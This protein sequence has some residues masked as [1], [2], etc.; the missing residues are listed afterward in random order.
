MEP[1]TDLQNAPSEGSINPLAGNIALCLSGGGYRAAA[2]HLG[3]LKALDEINVIDQVKYLSTASGGTILAAKFVTARLSG[4]FDFAAFFEE[5]KSFLT[6]VN[7]VSDSFARLNSNPDKTNKHS[8]IRCA[9]AVYREKLIGENDKWT[10]GSLKVAIAETKIFEDLIFNSSEFRT[11][12]NFRF[13]IANGRRL[14]F[15]NRNTQVKEELADQIHLADIVAASSCFPG[16]FEPIIFPQEFRLKDRSEAGNPFVTK[17]TKFNTL[18]LMDGG[19]LD[20]QGLYGMT[21]SYQDASKIPF[22]LLFVSD[23][24]GKEDHIY[25]TQDPKW[26]IPVSLRSVV[27]ILALLLA[28]ILAS[29]LTTLWWGTVTQVSIWYRLAILSTG[30]VTGIVSALLL[31][32]VFGG[33]HKLKNLQF[34]GA[35]FHLWQALGKLS[36]SEIYRFIKDRLKSVEA[37]T[38]D[39]FMNRIRGLQMNALMSSY[40]SK[41]QAS[42]FSTK[43]VFLNIYRMAGFQPTPHVD[44][45]EAKYVAE[46][47]L[48]EIE[49]VLIPTSSMIDVSCKAKA[50]GT[51]LWLSPDEFTVLVD[52][53]RLD[54]V[55]MLLEHVSK[56]SNSPNVQPN[57]PN[58]PFYVLY[59][60]WLACRHEFPDA[61]AKENGKSGVEYKELRERLVLS[62]SAKFPNSGDLDS[63]VDATMNRAFSKKVLQNRENSV[64][65]KSFVDSI[66]RQIEVQVR[67][68]ERSEAIISANLGSEKAW[69][70]LNRQIWSAI[71]SSDGGELLL[72]DVFSI[73]GDDEQTFLKILSLLT[74]L[75]NPT[76]GVLRLEFRDTVS[77]ASVSIEE[78]NRQLSAWWRDH[79][80][81]ADDWRSWALTVIVRWTPIPK[82]ETYL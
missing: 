2:Y 22:S 67:R 46:K 40:D 59:R 20:N 43:A 31:I 39:V 15:G 70:Q 81:S 8:L 51:K 17:N 1:L 21:I 24:S 56:P 26:K 63:I 5:S 10:V 4:A 47:T 44:A 77:D 38:F 50:V 14:L 66:A 41:N 9:A 69:R 82:W 73:G 52:C 27:V 13:R 37:M 48:T 16:V 53:G 35:T 6:Q 80:I 32:A 65:S 36:V 7:I 72:S 18:A 49:K 71:E 19:I 76:N 55:R 58:S 75:S 42:R 62:L 57:D 33:V 64:H 25:E 23:T 34:D 68:T 11:G 28:L 61:K 12:N 74:V 79:F 29:A 54:T 78:F 3:V 60:R 30:T 45:E